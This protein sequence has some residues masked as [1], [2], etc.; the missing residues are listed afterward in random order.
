[1]KESKAKVI[2]FKVMKAVWQLHKVGVKHGDLNM[3][4][5]RAKKKN[6]GWEV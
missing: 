1:M 5:I 3:D 6:N 4:T 2:V